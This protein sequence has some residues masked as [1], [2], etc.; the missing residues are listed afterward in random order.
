M[1]CKKSPALTGAC[2]MVKG[3][4][5]LTPGIGVTLMT[6]DGTQIIIKAPPDCN[7][8]I[9]PP[10]DAELALLAEQDRLHED[11]HH[12][13]PSSSAPCPPELNS[14]GIKDYRLHQPGHQDHP[15]QDQPLPGKPL[16]GRGHPA[17]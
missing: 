13:A 16:A 6:E 12:R 3:S 14:A 9:A 7:A 8:D 5:G 15:G 1:T 17:L 10:G 2:R 4:L 11:P